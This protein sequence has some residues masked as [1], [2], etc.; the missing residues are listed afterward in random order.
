MGSKEIRQFET[1]A[2]R[3]ASDHKFDYEGFLS[4]NV[5]T[6]Y[7][8][9]M[10][11]HRMQANGELRDSDN[12]QKGIPVKQYVK[13]LVRHTIDLWS[14]YRG[15]K[16]ACPD[17]GHDLGLIELCCAIMFNVQGL[18]FELLKGPAEEK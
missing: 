3:N 4:P 6:A 17:D 11:K 16:R 9:Y 2:T 12:W 13:S 7:A 18:L 15:N 14:V 1:G 8:N 10:H 5:L